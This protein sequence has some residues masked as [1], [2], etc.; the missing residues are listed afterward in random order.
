MCACNLTSQ[1]R[2]FLFRCFSGSSS[3]LSG[4][5]THYEVLGVDSNASGKEIRTA[6][7]A[8]SKKHHPDMQQQQQ[9]GGSEHDSFLEISEAYS[10]LSD[11]QKRSSYNQRLGLRSHRTDPNSSPGQYQNVYTG[12]YKRHVYNYKPSPRSSYSYFVGSKPHG[13]IHDFEE[14][15]VDRIHVQRGPTHSLTLWVVT[16]LGIAVL[17]SYLLRRYEQTSKRR[18]HSTLRGHTSARKALHK[19]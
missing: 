18:R 2:T 16:F 3:H 8:L 13:S 10:V 7:L 1:Q 17:G 12:S 15:D 6:Y 14:E 5:R 11:P 4:R 19:E 9:Q